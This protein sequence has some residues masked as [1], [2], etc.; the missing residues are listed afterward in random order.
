[1]L[2]RPTH[3]GF[4]LIELLVVIAII[5]I[6]A[7]ILFPVF[8]KVREK[9]RQATCASN[10]KQE[11]LATLEYVQD[12][13]EKYPTGY[14]TNAANTQFVYWYQ[15]I[16]PYVASANANVATINFCPSA[17]STSAMAY[18]MNPRV[19]GDSTDTF[20]NYTSPAAQAQLTHPS[21]TILYGDADQIPNYG[22]N[23]LTLFRVN[24]GSVN[25][26][27]WNAFVA[28]TTESAWDSI[29]N[30]TNI[31]ATSPGQ[32]RYRHTGLANFAFCDGH[33]KA[34]HRGSVSVYN[35]QISGDVAD[36]LTNS[37]LTSQYQTYR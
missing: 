26:G 6:L 31:D 33:V 19:G 5:A 36:T 13:D 22:N 17:P 2:Q 12:Y 16:M 30:D 21:D 4:T 18:S 14:W 24:P 15:I 25:G 11:G 10:L 20:F 34:M 28:P 32:V 23:P 3:K 27:P 37:P 35:W 1:M 9:A 7:A 29:D 8:A